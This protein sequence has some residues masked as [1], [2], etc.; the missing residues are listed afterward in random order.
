M[1]DPKGTTNG[2]PSPANRAFSLME[3]LISVGVIA[4]LAG[5]LVPAM[6]GVM[7]KGKSS[8]DAANLRQI[9]QANMAYAAD[10]NMRCVVGYTDNP[11]STGSNWYLSLRPYLEKEGT[12]SAALGYL[13]VL[14]SPNDPTKGGLTGPNALSP[15]SALRRS[16]AINYYCREFISGSTR[17]YRGRKMMQMPAS[18]MIFV[19]DY[20]AVQVGT[21]GI[22]PNSDTSLAALPR[23][24]HSTK[25]MAQFVFLDGHVE[26]INV[27]DLQSGGGRYKEAWGAAP[28]TVPR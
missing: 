21:H 18:T 20:P 23:D 1:Q 24:W 17:E 19:G 2:H 25:D 8:K 7:L 27:N 10:N 26:M 14:V 13:P 11:G 9:A 28:S 22:S 6:K 5:L 3:L 15:D 4:L 16:Y 12:T